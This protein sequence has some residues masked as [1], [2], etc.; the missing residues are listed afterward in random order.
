MDG[1]RNLN[2]T[3]TSIIYSG[4]LMPRYISKENHY[5]LDILKINSVPFISG[6]VYF[7]NNILRK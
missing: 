6:F 1:T 7:I 2:H 4:P 5:S 3:P